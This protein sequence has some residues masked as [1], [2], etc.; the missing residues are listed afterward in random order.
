MI[1][2]NRLKYVL[3]PQFDIYREVSKI[4][5]GDVAD[6]GCGTG[7]GTH[8]LTCNA[9]HVAGYEIDRDALRFAETV[10]PLKSLSFS[11]GDLVEGIEGQF[12]FVIMIDVIEHIKQDKQA[13][14]NAKKMLHPGGKLI[15]STPNRLSRYRK[16]ENHV[17]EYGPKELEGILKRVYRK[18]ELKNYKLKPLVSQYENPMIAIC[19]I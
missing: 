12:D 7:F 9:K 16:S 3:S 6:I 8:L 5:Q 4:V 1:I 18:V 13:L 11:Y 15:I 10:F 17:R 2:W 19:G 14:I